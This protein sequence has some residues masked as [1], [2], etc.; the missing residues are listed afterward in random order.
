MSLALE[1]E[2]FREKMY[3]LSA[4]LKGYVKGRHEEGNV[5]LNELS[6][7]SKLS[8]AFIRNAISSKLLDRSCTSVALT[9]L[10]VIRPR[11]ISSFHSIMGMNRKA[12]V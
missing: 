10:R 4:T 7:D 5:G 3:R 9:F 2:D 12:Q 11:P 8:P 6:K 1:D